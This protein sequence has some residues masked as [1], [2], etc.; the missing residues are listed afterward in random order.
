MRYLGAAILSAVLFIAAVFTVAQAQTTNSGKVTLSWTDNS[1]N[2]EGFFIYRD[3]KQIGQV[4][5]NETTF[6]DSVTGTVGQ[7]FSYQVSAFNHQFV[8]GSGNLQESV[9]SNTAVFTLPPP[10]QSPPTAP[11]NL[12][13]A[14]QQ[15]LVELEKAVAALRAYQP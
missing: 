6:V 5:A 11:S 15:A 3:G 13:Q 12:I 9:K 10:T 2:E 14:W 7:Q 1:T 8:D 4:K